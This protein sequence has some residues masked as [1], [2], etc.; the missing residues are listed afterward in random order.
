MREAGFPPGVINIIHGEAEVVRTIIAQPTI[1]TMS[2]VG[3]ELAGLNVW[4]QCRVRRVKVQANVSGKNH[5]VIMPDSPKD[6]AINALVEGAFGGAGQRC[7]SPKVA[8]LVGEASDWLPDI[9]ARAQRLV[10]GESMEGKVD[11]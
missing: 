7:M 5:L 1:N 11:L 4:D 8:V 10:V 3:S 2:F 6:F 9:V